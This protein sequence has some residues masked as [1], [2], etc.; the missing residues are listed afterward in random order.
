[1]RYRELLESAGVSGPFYHV[2]T[3]TRLK[4]IMT[5]GL[6]PGHRR[7][8]KNTFGAKLG[9]RGYIYLISNFTEAVKWAAK[10]DYEHRI[11]K[12]RS[13]TVIL[14]LHNVPTASIDRDPNIEGQLRGHSWFRSTATVP[15]T[16]IVRVIPLSEE[17]VKQVV[18]DGTVKPPEPEPQPAAEPPP[19]S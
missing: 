1:M 15:P 17:L 19:Q 13:K 2:T 4:S 9:D 5:N 3:D 7:R 18:K 16:D 6:E 12:K 14:V 11:E 8:W 10:Q